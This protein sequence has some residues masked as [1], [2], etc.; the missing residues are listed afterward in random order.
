MDKNHPEVNFGK[1]GVLIINL[2]LH[3]TQQIGG[4]SESI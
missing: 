4:I 1:S 2:A 3:Q